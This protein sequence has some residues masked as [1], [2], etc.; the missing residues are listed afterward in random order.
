VV[1]K[2]ELSSIAF[3]I[4]PVFDRKVRKRPRRYRAPIRVHYGSSTDGS[5]QLAKMMIHQMD[6]SIHLGTLH[7]SDGGVTPRPVVDDEDYY[8]EVGKYEE[9]WG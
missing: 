4:N 8:L 5:S 1:L 6:T 7:D 3:S 9:V 2:R